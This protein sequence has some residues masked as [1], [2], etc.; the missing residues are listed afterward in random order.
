[1]D[2]TSK[3]RI[4]IFLSTD[5]NY[6][7]PAY[8]TLYSLM[9]NYRG[10][11]RVNVHILTSGDLSTENRRLLDMLSEKRPLFEISVI[12]MQDAYHDVNFNID[13][14]SHAAMYRL[15]IP[16]I[17]E[18]LHLDADTC[19][20]IDTD[21]VVEGDISE[22]YDLDP[23]R[24]DW[25]FAGVP[26]PCQ[27][28]E[29]HEVHTCRLGIPAMDQYINSG[30]LLINLK[31]IRQDG[32]C[33]RLE[34]AG[35]SEGFL[36][37]DQDA[38]NSVCY[39]RILLIPLKF[40]MMRQFFY[41]NDRYFSEVYDPLYGRDAAEAKRDPVIIHFIDRQKPWSHKNIL[42]A[43]KWWKYVNMQSE[44]TIRE[45]IAP[46]AASHR[47]PLSGRILEAGRTALARMNL[48]DLAGTV[49]RWFTNVKAV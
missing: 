39:G 32:L 44:R 46:F 29:P 25:Y 14:I 12:D 28:Y 35:Y 48:Y 34:E 10:K 23:G 40:N 2:T 45:Y 31:Q 18:Q 7:V 20:Y 26:D 9:H 36:Y 11:R 3:N 43:E 16:R 24:E 41:H 6:S 4:H 30:V 13:H 5:N 19:I 33:E 49:K 38:I 27:I 15:M 1:M 22:L 8:I 47:A 17:A 21:I 42:M 37:K